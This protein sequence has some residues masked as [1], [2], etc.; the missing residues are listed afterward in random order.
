MNRSFSLTNLEHCQLTPLPRG[1]L[2]QFGDPALF[3]ATV[4]PRIPEGITLQG[5]WKAERFLKT[6]KAY[7]VLRNMEIGVD[8]ELMGPQGQR[9]TD[10]FKASEK[11]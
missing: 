2:Q 8:Q 11:L 7:W 4:M 1:S 9:L 10:L 3:L 5:G 6:M